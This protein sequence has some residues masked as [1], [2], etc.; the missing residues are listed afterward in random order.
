MFS[1]I[2]KTLEEQGFSSNAIDIIIDSWRSSTRRQYSGYIQKWLGFSHEREI[3]S[4]RPSTQEIIEFLTYLFNSGLKYSVIG[5]ARS[6]L[7]M[8]ICICSKK[9][10]NLGED[11]FIKRFMKG[12]YNK[13]PK[14]PRYSSIW[15]P[16]VVLTHMKS[17]GKELSLQKLTHKTV[18]LL[19]LL[20][21]QRGQFSHMLKVQDVSFPT[22]FVEFRITD[23]MKQSRPGFHLNH[24]RLREYSE[25]RDL[26]VVHSLKNYLNSTKKLRSDDKLFISLQAPHKGVARGTISRWIKTVLQEAGIDTGKLTAHST[27]AAATSAAFVKGLPVGTILKTVGWSQ[28]STFRRFYNKPVEDA[29][30]LQQCLLE[31]SKDRS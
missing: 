29:A 2:R 31:G 4:F 18:M 24:I 17:W 22:D 9:S 5:T 23:L 1:V 14:P 3:N 21:A 30:N 15:N 12:I 10:V 20:T 11:P 7:S 28:N 25:D 26:C 13:R 8:F 27:R 16:D 19:A 6:A